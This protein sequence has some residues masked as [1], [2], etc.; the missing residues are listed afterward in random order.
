MNR[1]TG[2]REREE[3][4]ARIQSEEACSPAVAAEADSLPERNKKSRERSGAAT[5]VT[6]ALRGCSQLGETWTARQMRLA[7]RI[8]CHKNVTTTMTGNKPTRNQAL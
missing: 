3:S 6:A 7:V 5:S 2:D 8:T 4:V 1:Q